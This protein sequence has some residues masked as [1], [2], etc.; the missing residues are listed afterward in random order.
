MPFDKAAY[1]QEYKK[2]NA[3]KWPLKR[4]P[5]KKKPVKIKPVSASRAK[6]LRVYEKEKAEFFK[7][8][9]VCQYPGC[10]SEDLDLHHKV[11]RVGKNLTDRSNFAGLCRK[12]HAIIEENPLLA[13]RLGLSGSRL[14]TT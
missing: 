12:H 10:E 11:G 5:L 1:W 14:K 6:A 3:G 9:K 13:L 2:A 7:E 8:V 4:S